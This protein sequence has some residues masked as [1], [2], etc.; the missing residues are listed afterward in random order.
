MERRQEERAPS[1]ASICAVCAICVAVECREYTSGL[2][3][4]KRK[5][6]RVGTPITVGLLSL[7]GFDRSFRR[8]DV[9]G[10]IDFPYPR[11][12]VSTQVLR[13]RGADQLWPATSQPSR[14]MPNDCRAAFGWRPTEDRHV[15]VLT[16]LPN[17]AP[18]CERP[19]RASI[20][21]VC[22]RRR[23]EA[24]EVQQIVLAPAGVFTVERRVP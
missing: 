7:A 17:A 9:R 1:S 23:A 5:P 14:P 20:R 18:R 21:N 10:L 6:H 22:R 3:A 19:S 8:H 2:T 11:R 13:V 15:R 12:T 16:D 24:C 4:N